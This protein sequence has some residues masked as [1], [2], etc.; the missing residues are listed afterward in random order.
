MASPYTWLPYPFNLSKMKTKKQTIKQRIVATTVMLFMLLMLFGVL[1]PNI[2][3]AG[4]NTT[5]NL[6]QNVVAGALGHSAMQNL[7][8]TD[9]NIGT[10]SNTTSNMTQTNVWDYRGSGVGWSVTGYCNNLTINNAAAGVNNISNANIYWNPA[11]GTIVNLSGVSTGITL[12]TLNPLNY[13]RTLVTASGGN[14]MGNYRVY[15][16]MLNVVY[17]GRIDQ[18]AGTYQA[19]LTM[20]SS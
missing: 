15:N 2:T 11:P 19:V 14:G 4:A 16:V 9:I 3:L 5:T 6:I 13:S 7:V 10:A 8:F 1:D 17:D 18:L 12:G 20:T